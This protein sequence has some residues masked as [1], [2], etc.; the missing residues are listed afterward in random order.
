MSSGHPLLVVGRP[1]A[2][3][4]RTRGG[5]RTGV[6]QTPVPLEDVARATA[7]DDGIVLDV[8]ADGRTGSAG[9]L[10][11]RVSDNDVAANEIAGGIHRDQ[12]AVDVS[13][14]A[15]V[16][17]HV[18]TASREQSDAEVIARRSN[19]AVPAEV[20][21]T[22]SIVMAVHQ[23]VAAAGGIAGIPRVPHRHDVFDDAL[24]HRIGEQAAEA[25]VIGRDVPDRGIRG[26]VRCPHDENAVASEPSD[27]ARP[28][29]LY[30]GLIEDANAVFISGLGRR[31]RGGTG[32][33]VR[34]GAAGDGEAV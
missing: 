29:Y 24:G 2:G 19:R 18:S 8:E 20:A 22:N 17:D 1:W 11:R 33:I 25:V 6:R 34:F 16:L 15:V 12:K 32:G 3:E 31:A 23:A 27:D 28:D 13:A 14:D 4:I 9:D 26:D 21:P 10:T 30:V 7:G 5:S